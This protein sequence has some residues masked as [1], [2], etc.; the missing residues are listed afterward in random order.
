[1]TAR[2]ASTTDRNTHRSLSRPAGQ[3]RSGRLEPAQRAEIRELFEELAATTDAR[4]RRQLRD[5]LVELNLPLVRHLARRF[6]HTAEPLDDVIQVGTLGLIKA[7]DRFDPERKLEFSTFAVPTVL[8]EIR[9]Y[10]RDAT[11]AVHVPRGARE[12]YSS[13]GTARADLAQRLGREPT[14]ADLAAQFDVTE[15]DIQTALDAGA[16]YASSSLESMADSAGGVGR[17][18]SVGFDDLRLDQV[19]SRADLRP[20]LAQLTRRQREVIVQRFVYD[21]SQTQIAAEL[22]V[23]QMQVSRLLARS[24][25]EL[26]A[27]L[28][29]PHGQHTSPSAA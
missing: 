17:D 21:R 9:R 13:I 19:E 27:L 10:F 5:R 4:R 7:V 25:R 8:G 24:T 11:W 28:G 29:V 1:M 18:A 20:A 14:N 16:G 15:R 6:S 26:R 3:T 2:T 23:S 12:L 22:G